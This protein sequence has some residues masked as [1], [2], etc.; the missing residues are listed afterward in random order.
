[1]TDQHDQWRLN[2]AE[3]L[4]SM[5]AM[6]Q[7]SFEAQKVSDAKQDAMLSEL[8]TLRHGS[9]NAQAHIAALQADMTKHG[10]RL[11]DIEAMP[12]R[13][14]RWAALSAL[15]V[16]GA[17]WGFTSSTLSKVFADWISRGGTVPH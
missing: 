17:L 12:W 13:A 4:G 14:A 3:H 6:L 10:Q 9:N 7:T 5:R 15:A 2:V 1:M 11:D 16:G 8:R